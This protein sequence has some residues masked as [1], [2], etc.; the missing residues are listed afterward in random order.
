MGAVLADMVD[1]VMVVNGLAGANGERV[2]AG[3]LAEVG[4]EAAPARAA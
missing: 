1:G 4:G 2:R 3:L